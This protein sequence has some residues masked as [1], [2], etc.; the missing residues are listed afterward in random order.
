M[1]ASRNSTHEIFLR[2]PQW[3]RSRPEVELSNVISSPFLAN[4]KTL[5]EENRFLKMANYRFRLI[6]QTDRYGLSSAAVARNEKR[7]AQRRRRLVAHVTH[8][9]WPIQHVVRGGHTARGPWLT[10]VQIVATLSPVSDR[11]DHSPWHHAAGSMA[12]PPQTSSLARRRSYIKP[13]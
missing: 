1:S 6:G 12:A 5:A 11:P 9:T 3:Q 10:S 13:R 8:G 7:S 2:I 4:V